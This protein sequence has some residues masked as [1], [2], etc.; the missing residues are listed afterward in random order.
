MVRMNLFRNLGGGRDAM[1]EVKNALRLGAAA[2]AAGE[3]PAPAAARWQAVLTLGSQEQMPKDFGFVGRLLS[4]AVLA[5]RVRAVLWLRVRPATVR[6]GLRPVNYVWRGRRNRCSVR[7]LPRISLNC[8]TSSGHGGDEAEPSP[9]INAAPRSTPCLPKSRPGS[10]SN[11]HWRAAN[12]GL[13]G[14][15]LRAPVMLCGYSRP[16][17]T[18]S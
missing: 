15:A 6:R 1:A 18:V 17:R 4:C 3:R 13:S 9:V 7:R 14:A 11:A 16:R 5:L 2:I 12:V 8:G 10:T